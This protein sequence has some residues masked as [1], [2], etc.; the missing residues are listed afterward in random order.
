[1]LEANLSGEKKVGWKSVKINMPVVFFDEDDIFYAYIPSFDLI[2]YGSSQ[3]EAKESLNVVLDEFLRYTLNKNTFFIELKRLG[4]KV[5]GKHKLITAPQLSDLVNT[6]D[7][8][9]DI[10]KY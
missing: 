2:G 7:Q 6:N 3:A 8:L 10:L 5:T 1:M 9:R 4:W